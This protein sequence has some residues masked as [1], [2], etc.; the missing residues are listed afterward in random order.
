MELLWVRGLLLWN[1]RRMTGG[2][3]ETHL[4]VMYLFYSPL[5]NMIGQKFSLSGP[6][7]WYRKKTR[8][9]EPLFL[10]CEKNIEWFCT[11][12]FNRRC[13]CFRSENSDA[14]LYLKLWYS[15]Y[16]RVEYQRLHENNLARRRQLCDP[17][18]YEF[19]PGPDTGPKR[20]RTI[21]CTSRIVK[22]YNGT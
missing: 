20:Q 22:Y 6:P 16:I 18:R 14:L 3:A 8:T 4:I 7:R 21:L 5:K 10:C 13:C 15:F 11:L 17:L 9:L 19:Y 1:G 12:F 2:S